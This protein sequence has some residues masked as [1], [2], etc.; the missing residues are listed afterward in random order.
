MCCAIAR[1]DLDLPKIA[2]DAQTYRGEL[3]EK[4]GGGTDAVFILRK[5]KQSELN[6][7]KDVA[8]LA[9][10]LVMLGIDNFSA[11]KRLS[12]A[13]QR[14]PGYADKALAAAYNG[15]LLARGDAQIIE[16]L[17]QLSV[18]FRGRA[19]SLQ[20]AYGELDGR[21]RAAQYRLQVLRASGGAT[22][23]PDTPAGETRESIASLTQNIARIEQ[24]REVVLRELM[25]TYGDLDAVYVDIASVTGR[26][27]PVD[28]KRQENRLTRF[29]K[30]SDTFT[31]E[32]SGQNVKACLPFTQKFKPAGTELQQ[33]VKV[34]L[35]GFPATDVVAAVNG[36]NLCLLGLKPGKYYSVNVNRQIQSEDGDTL[37]A[38]LAL[39]VQTENLDS[40]VTFKDGRFIL[41]A[42]GPGDLDFSVTNLR[43]AAL[44]LFRV[45]DRSLNRHIALGQLPGALSYREICE[46]TR[47]SAEKL[48]SGAIDLGAQ[49]G[50]S[51]KSVAVSLPIRRLLDQRLAWLG[52]NVTD[53][54][55]I[56]GKA[57]VS[58]ERGVELD[59]ASAFKAS[60][61]FHASGSKTARDLSRRYGV[62]ALI[63]RESN[64]GVVGTA[65]L[66]TETCG[67]G[68]DNEDTRLKVQW[69]VDTDI[70]LTYYVGANELTVVARS[71]KTGKPL[72]SRIEL[73]NAGNDLIGSQDTDEQGIARFPI[74]LTRGV[75]AN[76]MVGV[77]A[78]GGTDFSFVRYG[79][80]HLDL[81]RLDVDGEQPVTGLKT[82]L[83][84]ERGI[85]QPGESITLLAQIRDT[86]GNVPGQLPNLV[87]RLQTNGRT[88]SEQPIGHAMLKHGV[89][90][91][92]ID[93]GRNVRTGLAN[94]ALVRV[95]DDNTLA[96]VPV[97]IGA[98]RPDRAALDLG[99]PDDGS[100]T[101]IADG[102]G[103]FSLKGDALA[104][105]L[106]SS[107]TFAGG[108]VGGLTAEVEIRVDQINQELGGCFGNLA[109]GDYESRVVPVL[110]RRLVK[111]DAQGR[112]KLDLAGIRLPQ[113]DKPLQ[114]AVSIVLFDEVGPIASGSRRVR[115]AGQVEQWLGLSDRPIL[116]PGKRSGTFDLAVA[117]TG[118][119]GLG[120]PQIP[121]ALD[122]EL[123]RENVNFVWQK[124]VTGVWEPVYSADRPL[125]EKVALNAS[126]FRQR[127]ST[128][129]VDCLA[130]MQVGQIAEGLE[131]GRYTL[132]AVARPSGASTSVQFQ[133]GA[134][135]IEEEKLAPNLLDL[136]T[137]KRTYEAGEKALF[138]ISSPLDG[139][140]RIAF[141]DE[142]VVDWSVP[143]E[144]KN[145]EA[146]ITV[147]IKQ[148]WPKR[149]LYAL[150]SV[151][152]ANADGSRKLGPSR[153]IGA[154]HFSVVDA[155]DRFQ[156][157]IDMKDGSQFSVHR[158]DQQLEFDICL[159]DRNDNCLSANP[160]EAYAVA[161]VVDQ[162][163]LNQTRHHESLPDPARRFY[164]KQK[165]QVTLMDNYG[166]LLLKE[167]GDRPNRLILSNYTTDHIVARSSGIQKLTQGR[168][169]F[170]F[171]DLGLQ[172]GNLS[173]VVFAWSD[174]H[175]DAASKNIL[176]S[177]PLIAELS[178]PDA[179][180]VGDTVEVPLRI[181]NRNH[182]HVGA[183]KLRFNLSDG[184]RINGVRLAGEGEKQRDADGAYQVVLPRGT[185]K[186]AFV[187]LA[188][189]GDTSGR[190]GFVKVD[191]QPLS[192]IIKSAPNNSDWAFNWQSRIRRGAPTSVETVSFPIPK[193]GGKIVLNTLARDLI[194]KYHANDLKLGFSVSDSAA[195]LMG[196]PTQV[197]SDDTGGKFNRLLARGLILVNAA[198]TKQET[199][200]EAE[201][202]SIVNQLAALQL[203]DGMFVPYRTDGQF[204]PEELGMR[205]VN[206]FDEDKE[207][208]DGIFRTA[209]AVHFLQQVAQI[210]A[211]DTTLIESATAYINQQVG[212]L[213]KAQGQY[214]GQETPYFCRAGSLYGIFVLIAAQQPV[215][216]D[217]IEAMRFC[218]IDDPLSR[219]LAA[220][221]DQDYGFSDRAR[222]QLASLGD[223]L[224]DGTQFESDVKT[225]M[226]LYFLAKADV[227]REILPV[228]QSG[229]QKI[230]LNDAVSSQDI[231]AWLAQAETVLGEQLSTGSDETG[232][233]DIRFENAQSD[234]FVSNG[235]KIWHSKLQDIASLGTAPLA[236]LNDGG[237]T[238]RGLLTLEGTLINP[239]E[240]EALPQGALRKRY[241]D[242]DTRQEIRPVNGTLELPHGKRVIV[243]V[244]AE[245]NAI[246]SLIASDGPLAGSVSRALLL[247]DQLPST[248][249]VVAVNAFKVEPPIRAGAFD[250]LD[251]RGNMRSVRQG[252][253]RLVSVLIPERF[254]PVPQE[255]PESNDN[256]TAELR[257]AYLTRVALAGEF[258]VPAPTL[259]A[260]DPPVVTRRGV[261][262]T[263]RVKSSEQ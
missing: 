216:A 217:W 160:A 102:N 251:Q 13:W 197:A 163:I 86:N 168:T 19:A 175:S 43:T 234:Q 110:E 27:N 258:I 25:A 245:P 17:L 255:P 136:S 170:S 77:L 101:A 263:I 222:V 206:V 239:E 202:R 16:A 88:V 185:V 150:A 182:V 240:R 123:R 229:V 94:V 45:T 140:G 71:L 61:N 260:V 135:G 50:V 159:S 209:G 63:A 241:F 121:S 167:G 125:V 131:P 80:Q 184:L 82:Y 130:R 37:E 151:Y 172:S 15:Y 249:K 91:V 118:L 79:P 227:D 223:E 104:R 78:Y 113:T 57:V 246:D 97:T 3:A 10:Q 147:D 192:S 154:A 144:V 233:I 108:S 247:V 171:A 83:Y 199:G 48:W 232:V 96:E 6:A 65:D 67:N 203:D 84:T 90:E 181:A 188:V 44:E 75:K 146:T 186:T 85:Y 26:I 49:N 248:L 237:K 95:S 46:M 72:P 220:A 198:K 35:D 148:E 210:Q 9:E 30:E 179:L 36:K 24:E 261:A 180:H 126:D 38:D 20:E 76:R 105:Y 55:F 42:N 254:K 98:I 34:L 226:L 18:A 138:K 112:L 183:Y 215:S 190:D 23:S 176:V 173:I 89:A 132:A 7:D 87:A 22:S 178:I 259:E 191:L 243:V 187:S 201:L 133:V 129:A 244:E 14:L 1:A 56:S 53:D 189:E 156:V 100:W 8:D 166:Q 60:G 29:A 103:R 257:I 106:F 124:T 33:Y 31:F 70:G 149:G 120:A 59:A 214:S 231:A 174:K 164:G 69:F 122:L 155:K 152:R 196:R 195:A 256:S 169:K 119:S 145:G 40:A 252:G 54:D 236:I 225:A 141:V 39:Y 218:N 28:L 114:A 238:A 162:G 165:L 81:S 74:A 161:Y 52:D 58:V 128:Q 92:N 204:T 213:Y 99:D 221:I 219:A 250:A 12:L 177:S 158:P 224:Q 127:E 211:V 212:A 153:A 107:D 262:G 193:N 21:Y 230:S 207:F 64:N 253:G 2:H 194:A 208:R 62:Y 109:F 115:I 205:K 242:F 66:G 11:W 5:L 51:N 157:R 142:D 111:A 73:I 235:P 139:P 228:I 93:V 4:S 143:F 32:F 47:Y 134:N 137:D 41:P 117:F 200:R 116:T 68:D